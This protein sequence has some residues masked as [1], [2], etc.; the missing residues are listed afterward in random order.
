[1]F[2]VIAFESPVAAGLEIL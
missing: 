1:M 2:G